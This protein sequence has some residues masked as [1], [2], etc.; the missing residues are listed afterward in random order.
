MLLIAD[1]GATKTSWALVD[2][3]KQIVGEY[4]TMGFSPIFHSKTDITNALNGNGDLMMW[5]LQI[6]QVRYFG[7]GCSSPERNAKI[8]DA[9]KQVFSHAHIF[10]EHDLLGAA[11]AT[12]GNNAGIACILGT[13]S[14]SCYFDGTELHEVVP[15]LDF[16]LSDEG[17][18]TKLGMEL[19][20]QYM[21]NRLPEDLHNELLNTYHL[22][23]EMVLRK[24]YSESHP[25]AFLSSFAKFMHTHKENPAI[26]EIVLNCFDEFLDYRVTC[27]PNYRQIPVHFVGSIAHYFADML[28][29]ATQKRQ[30]QLGK[31]IQAP[32]YGLVEHFS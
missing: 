16:I 25:K 17:S 12:C 13:G 23:K 22:D 24:V 6:T 27:Y 21:Y 19:I 31:I 3:Q 15:S 26:Q 14:N 8:H 29:I 10:I 1:S 28:V 20:R 7:A 32:I 30:I 11:I 4:S 5:A 9:L 2:A 18:G